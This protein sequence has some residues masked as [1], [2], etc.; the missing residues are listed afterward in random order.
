MKTKASNDHITTENEEI[1]PKSFSSRICA[2]CPSKS[3]TRILQATG[4]KVREIVGVS[5]EL[6]SL[7]S[8]GALDEAD[9]LLG[10][11][12]KSFYDRNARGER[13]DITDEEVYYGDYRSTGAFPECNAVRHALNMVN[14]ANRRKGPADVHM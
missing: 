10:K 11:V 4:D 13:G 5:C 2:I 8:R 3:T 9:S 12:S 6:Q 7:I 1:M 14:A